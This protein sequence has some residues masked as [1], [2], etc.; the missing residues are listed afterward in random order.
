MKQFSNIIKDKNVLLE[1]STNDLSMIKSY[2]INKLNH[3]ISEGI[4]NHK[5]HNVLNCSDN[6]INEF[7]DNFINE[8]QHLN[9]E[10]I[11]NTFDLITESDDENRLRFNQLFIELVE[12][13]K[14]TEANQT[15][16]N[17]KLLEC[18][19]INPIFLFDCLHNLGIKVAEQ[20]DIKDVLS[21]QFNNKS[22][23]NNIE[24]KQD[25]KYL[26]YVAQRLNE[27]ITYLISF[28]NKT[29]NGDKLLK[30]KSDLNKILHDYNNG[31]QEINLEESNAMQYFNLFIS[32]QHTLY[33]FQVSYLIKTLKNPA[34]FCEICLNF[35]HKWILDKQQRL[36]YTYDGNEFIKLQSMIDYYNKQHK[37]IM[38][39]NVNIND[40]NILRLQE[41]LDVLLSV[42]QMLRMDLRSIV[43]KYI[44]LSRQMITT[45]R[46]GLQ[47][48]Y[49]F[50]K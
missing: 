1:S 27:T 5:L 38:N 15:D 47:R 45:Y 6:N 39:Y 7:I 28:A 29:L 48:Q 44:N 37:I 21:E 14:S 3:Q 13:I 25:A 10:Q 16:I 33:N 34:T 50:H 42:S 12:V 26:I 23:L 43:I 36:S 4:L 8:N 2:C 18:Y 19:V 35:I 11:L 40:V 30:F 9:N 20:I 31:V 17:K 24:F 32:G 49:N 22:F 41:L 46:D